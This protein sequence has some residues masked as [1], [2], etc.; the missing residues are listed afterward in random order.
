MPGPPG[1][2]GT[3]ESM[4]RFLPTGNKGGGQLAAKRIIS[5]SS[6][7]PINNVAV[8]RGTLQP[9][10]S[11]PPTNWGMVSG[12]ARFSAMTAS[13]W[14]NTFESRGEGLV[15]VGPFPLPK[16]HKLPASPLLPEKTWVLRMV[17]KQRLI[18][19]L[20]SGAPSAPVDERP[21]WGPAGRS[22][23][24]FRQDAEYRAAGATESTRFSRCRQVRIPLR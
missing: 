16:K 10:E 6:C 15:R 20:R 22:I 23:A 21:V 7:V 12:T 11:R 3:R 8:S 1:S 9:S 2:R 18:R 17:G 13:E 14:R 5:A 4:A 24:T 19:F